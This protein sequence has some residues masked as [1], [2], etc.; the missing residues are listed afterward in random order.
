MI[1]LINTRLVAKLMKEVAKE[2]GMTRVY[3]STDNIWWA[4]RRALSDLGIVDPSE[5]CRRI[6]KAYDF[7]ADNFI[8]LLEAK[9][10][11]EGFD[12]ADCKVTLRHRGEFRDFSDPE[13]KKAMRY[14][15]DNWDEERAKGNSISDIKAPIIPNTEN[16]VYVR[17]VASFKNDLYGMW[18]FNSDLKE[19]IGIG[20]GKGLDL[21]EGLVNYY[22]ESKYYPKVTKDCEFGVERLQ[23]GEQFNFLFR[24][25]GHTY[26]TNYYLE[27]TEWEEK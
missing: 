25:K 13:Y 14:Y 1:K 21:L 12:L 20:H 19:A 9:V 27:A 23:T 18:A 8:E 26:D 22:I 10:K 5:T 16:S 7:I 11:A 3:S 2:C 6:V 24:E 15:F 4:K 17:L